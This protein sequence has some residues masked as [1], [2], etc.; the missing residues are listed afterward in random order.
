MHHKNGAAVWVSESGRCVRGGDGTLLGYEGFVSDITELKQAESQL[1]Q[2]QKME[3]VGQLTGGIAHDFNNLLA[4][5]I[6][7]LEIAIDSAGS[8]ESTRRLLATAMRAADRGATLTQRLLAFSRKQPLHPEAVDLK[9]LIEGM[10][11]LLQRTLGKSIEIRLTS[12]PGLWP[13]LADPAQLESVILNLAI[14]ARDAMSEGGILVIAVSNVRLDNKAAAARGGIPAG[15]YLLLTVTDT[16]H[17]MPDDVREHAFDPFF[18]TKDSGAGSGL[19][20]SMVYGFAKQSDGH[21]QIHSQVASGTTVEVYLPRC[22]ANIETAVETARQNDLPM[23]RGET[24]LIVED[25]GDLRTLIVNILQCL[26]YAVLE[27]GTGASALHQ[28]EAAPHVNLLFSD[29]VLPGG[30]L[31]EGFQLLEKPFR[32]ADIA[33]AVRS[34]L[35]RG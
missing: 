11:D 4:V 8:G 14:N 23:A 9:Q 31:D 15:D 3:A 26:G 17:G 29:V 12:D 32:K 1:H 7:N 2:A 22:A 35:D 21:V 18:T 33:R 19:G 25:D 10:Q 6:G 28:L 13:C 27:A 24:V 34:A 16:G 30:R 20:L 5:I